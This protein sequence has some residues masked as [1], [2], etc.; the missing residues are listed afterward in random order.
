VY[1]Q[2]QN[3]FVRWLENKFT[4]SRS[5]ASPRHQTVMDKMG[6]IIRIWPYFYFNYVRAN[7]IDQDIN[8]LVEIKD[9]E[10]FSVS[11]LKLINFHYI[12]SVLSLSFIE[13]L[14]DD[15]FQ[16]HFRHMQLGAHTIIRAQAKADS[17]QKLIKIVMSE[18]IF[19]D[20]TYSWSRTPP[21]GEYQSFYSIKPIL[22]AIQRKL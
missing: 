16:S 3:C 13:T 10:E 15:M 7:T 17:P 9:T 8:K 12:A 1:L 6:L 18:L 19:E 5:S 20:I 14:K 21:F 2:N 22:Y 11:L 4:L